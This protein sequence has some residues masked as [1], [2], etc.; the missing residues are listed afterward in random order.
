MHEQRVARCLT[1]RADDELRRVRLEVAIA[2]W[3]GVDRTEQLPQVGNVYLYDLASADES[4]VPSARHPGA[5]VTTRKVSRAISNS[6]SVGLT[7][8]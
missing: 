6:S 1:S 5:A 3:R 7:H 4:L 8:N 2:E